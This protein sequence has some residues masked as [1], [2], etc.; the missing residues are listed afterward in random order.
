M[1][2]RRAIRGKPYIPLVAG[3]AFVVVLA[4]LLATGVVQDWFGR[5]RVTEPQYVGVLP[6]NLIGGDSTKMALC[7]GVYE[8]VVSGLVRMHDALGKSNVCP[9][10]EMHKYKVKDVRQAREGL[11]ITLG[12]EGTIHGSPIRSALRSPWWRQTSLPVSIPGR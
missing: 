6:F 1:Q 7:D 3:G 12:V 8:R 5:S 9:A 11:S 2:L 4:M 10:S